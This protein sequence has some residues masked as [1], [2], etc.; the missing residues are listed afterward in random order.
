M[1]FSRPIV[2]AAR[3]PFSP[4]S[5]QM[6]NTMRRLRSGTRRMMGNLRKPFMNTSRSLTSP[7]RRGGSRKTR[8]SGRR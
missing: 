7:F 8:R 3:N 5:K 1:S 4:N 6:R 2:A